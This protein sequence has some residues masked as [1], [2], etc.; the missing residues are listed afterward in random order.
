MFRRRLKCL[1]IMVLAGAGPAIRAGE[2]VKKGDFTYHFDHPGY[3]NLADSALVAVRVQV[4]ALLGVEQ[5]FPVDVYMV[6]SLASFDSLIGG[7]FPDW[8]AAAAVP[9]WHRIVVKSPERFRLGR[10][11]GELLRHEYAHLALDQRTGLHAAPRW[12]DEGLAMVVSME[13]S[14][15]D[16]ITMGVSAVLGQ[17]IPL[18]DLARMNLFPESQARL[19]YAQAYM[20]VQYLIE[21][22]GT[23]AVHDFLDAI[24]RGESVDDALMASVGSNSADFESELHLYWQSRFNLLTVLTSS[25]YFWLGLALILIV[26]GFLA[27]RRRRQYYRKWEEQEKFASTDFE[28]G[29]PDKP[30]E[31]DDDEPWHR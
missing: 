4:N 28:Y 17:F 25:M 1:L 6:E 12:F 18:S 10:P 3:V 16:N 21:S 24:A 13:W 9:M 23:A 11:L 22:Y 8:G 29:D 19:A 26:G 2:P 31:T 5:R 20:A 27:F 7:K 30:E 15:D 14:W